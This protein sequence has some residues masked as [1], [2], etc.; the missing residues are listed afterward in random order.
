MIARITGQLI[1]KSI[2]YV[3]VDVNGVGYLLFVPLST[4]YEI[5]EINQP[6]T[7]HVQTIVKDDT[8][9]L[10]GF[11]TFEE[12]EV[13]QSMISVSGIGPKLA[14]NVLSGISARDLIKAVSQGDLNC[15]IRIPGVGKKMAERIILEL[16][17]KMVKLVT[18]GVF[19]KEAEL[20]STD[21]IEKD[22]ISALVNLGYKNQAAKS[23]LEKVINEYKEEP[24]TL[25]VLL[26]RSL[27]ILAA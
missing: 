4:L 2:N 12:K 7:L 16:K 10:F 24:M 3:I 1:H 6:I 21:E 25:E 11:Y 22:A 17:D 14:L 20:R 8:I 23:A 26:K 18:F 9:N 19:D 15:L 13:F 5:K 27:K